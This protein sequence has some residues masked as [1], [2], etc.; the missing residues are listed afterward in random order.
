[1]HGRS[2]AGANLVCCEQNTQ[3]HPCSPPSRNVA[4]HQP[5]GEY[6]LSLH[7]KWPWWLQVACVKLLGRWLEPAGFSRSA[8]PGVS[9]PYTAQ[10]ST[11]C[12][13]SSRYVAESK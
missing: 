11:R 10:M 12:V 5:F 13:Q 9:T 3:S 4:K 7:F 6:L 1:M 8:G 2:L